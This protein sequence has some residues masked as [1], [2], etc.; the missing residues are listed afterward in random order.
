MDA[1]E[2]K[3]LRQAIAERPAGPFH[4]SDLYGAEWDKIR[5]GDKV[6]LGNAFQRAVVRHEFENVEDT[7]TKRGG[8]RLYI[9]GGQD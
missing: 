8:G 3:K 9:K 1:S 5:I 7:G 4:F 2:T 6:K